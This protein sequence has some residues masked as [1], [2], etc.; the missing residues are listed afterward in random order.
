MYKLYKHLRDR[1]SLNTILKLNTGRVD[2]SLKDNIFAE[3]KKKTG[4]QTD[5]KYPKEQSTNR[6][7]FAGRIRR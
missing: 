4:S 1:C 2:N 7:R 6:N 5:K 3:N